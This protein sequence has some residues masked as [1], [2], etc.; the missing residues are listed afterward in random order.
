MK[1]CFIINPASGKPET[2]KGLEERI[3]EACLAAEAE[4]SVLT[5]KAPRE[6][7]KLINEYYEANRDDEICFYACGGDGTLCE[8]VGAVVAL[9]DRDRV[10]VGVVPVG[11]GNDFVKSFSSAESFLDISAQLGGKREKIDVLRCNDI[12]A[13]NMINIG[14]DSEVVVKT[15]DLKKKS[16][17][18]SKLAYILGLA[19]TLIKKPGVEMTVSIDGGEPIHKRLLLTTFANGRFCGGGFHSNPKAEL[20]DGRIDT[21]FIQNVSRI[22]FISMVGDYKKG[23]HLCKKYEKIIENVKSETYDITFP[24]TTNVSID[25]EIVR[26]DSAKISVEKEALSV[27]VPKGIETVRGEESREEALV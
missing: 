5:T 4:Y 25:G 22:Q 19:I 8:V 12:Y 17:V 2:K 10:S 24:R 13:V 21:L 15:V 26:M 14:F 20:T 23:T 1:H 6:A 9:D 3:R 11:T 16:W 27:I 7:G 18:P